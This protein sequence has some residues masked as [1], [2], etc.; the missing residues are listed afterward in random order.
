MP[1]L[2]EQINKYLVYCEETR[3]MTPATMKNKRTAMRSLGEFL[4]QKGVEDMNDMDDRLVNQW[5]AS[6]R[7]NNNMPRTVNGKLKN[8]ILFVR[9]LRDMGEPV[10]KVNLSLIV[11]D[12][13]TEPE[14]VFYSREQIDKA[15]S[16]A[17]RREWLLIKLCFDCG[18]RI[19]EART[20]RLQ[21]I[22][23]D[24]LTILG[25]GRKR[26]FVYMPP[27]LQIRLQDWIER[28]KVTD[29]V[30]E[31]QNKNALSYS[32][33]QRKMRVPFMQAGFYD[34][35]IHALRHSCAS[36]V[37]NDGNRMEDAQIILRHSSVKTTQGYVHQFNG[38]REIFQRCRWKK[39]EKLR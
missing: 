35:H 17:D 29:Y 3:N 12:R 26:D 6:F 39:D 14:R 1:K 30:F 11:K 9:F 33:C 25:K 37:V 32:C 18:L 38:S 34:F 21:N 19:G 20:L 16:Y 4:L 22:R 31:G 15:L 24:R 28:E 8:F 27:E 5:I 7:A 13:E 2:H 23:G 36:E 10:S